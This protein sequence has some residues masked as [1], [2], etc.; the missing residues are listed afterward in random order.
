M[1]DKPTTPRPMAA[2]PPPAPEKIAEA[3]NVTRSRQNLRGD[4]N[5]LASEE[6]YEESKCAPAVTLSERPQAHNGGMPDGWQQRRAN[7]VARAALAATILLF[8]A[9]LSLLVAAGS[10]HWT[11][12]AFFTVEM[13]FPATGFFI[14]LRARNRVGWI[15][16][17]AGLGL[18]VQAFCAGYAE[19]ALVERPGS[20]PAAP[21][22]AW[23]GEIIW[24]PQLL[25]ATM[26][27]F[28]L[29]PDGRVPSPR[30][31]WVVRLGV[32]GVL[33]AEANVAFEP[34]LYSYPEV[35]APLGGLISQSSLDVLATIGGLVLLPT[36][37]LAL[38]SLVARYR[39]SGEVARM[40]IKW[41]LYA[42]VAFLAAQLTFNVFEFGQNNPV[43]VILNGLSALLIPAAVAVAILKHRLYDVDI[44]INRTL[45][46]S[47]L[48]AVLALV[49]AGGVTGVGGLVRSATAQDNN[50]LVVAASTLAVAGLFR[51]ARSRIQALIDRRFYRRKYDAARALELFSTRLREEID[52]ES[53]TR[54]LLGVVQDTMQPAQVS[55]WLRERDGRT[56]QPA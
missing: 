34:R 23:F 3:P 55:L 10:I 19:Y 38:A 51:P 33:L 18:G 52:L 15:F 13:A 9:G 32:T 49:Y 43:L 44:I 29:F 54:E 22:L 1:E 46:Y 16:L 8:L 37:V 40:Q 45:V 5:L 7:G 30:W 47:A 12:A 42:A 2:R 25:M 53:L 6:L 24:L 11:T 48:T 4:G 28:L 26:F 36:M 14:V 27:L 39:H 31:R 50:N 21:F 41:F 20:L 56:G 17:W 35:R